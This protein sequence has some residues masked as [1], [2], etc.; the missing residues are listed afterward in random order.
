MFS[1]AVWFKLRP[2]SSF[3]IASAMVLPFGSML[4]RSAS[5][6]WD[7]CKHLLVLVWALHAQAAV[8]ILFAS[9]CYGG[10]LADVGCFC[11]RFFWGLCVCHQFVFVCVDACIGLWS[12][13]VVV[14]ARSLGFACFGFNCD[15]VWSGASSIGMHGVQH[16]GG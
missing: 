14:D 4:P 12:H 5:P 16:V 6:G 8:W 13:L 7:V 15:A 2:S 3:S 11:G 10:A 9:C 1:V